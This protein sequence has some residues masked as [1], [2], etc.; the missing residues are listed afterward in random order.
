MTKIYGK[1]VGWGAYTP[2]N[3]VTNHDLAQRYETS[4]EWIVQRTGISE[5]PLGGAG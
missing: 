4:H 5:R 2:A 1:I 3:V